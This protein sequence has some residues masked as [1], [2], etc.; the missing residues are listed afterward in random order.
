[1]RHNFWKLALWIW[2]WTT[3]TYC[4]IPL[5]SCLRG[6]ACGSSRDVTLCWVQT[7]AFQRSGSLTSEGLQWDKNSLFQGPVNQKEPKPSLIEFPAVLQW[8]TRAKLCLQITE[9]SPLRK[10][11]KL[12]S[13]IRTCIKVWFKAFELSMRICWTLCEV[14]Y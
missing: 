4:W 10:K 13:N 1:M 8:I 6:G 9:T 14:N 7:L 12:H 5:Y 2:L 11:S 3:K